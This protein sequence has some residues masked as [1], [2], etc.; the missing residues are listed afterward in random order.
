MSKPCNCKCG[1][2]GFREHG[3][4][5]VVLIRRDPPKTCQFKCLECGWKWWACRRYS[6]K[7]PDH[8][9]HSR[10]GMTD[11]D[12][13]DRLNDESLVVSANAAVFSMTQRGEKQL[14]TT[15]HSSNGSTYRFVEICSKG[16]KKKIALHRLVWMS[17]KRE[18]IPDG[19]DIDHINGKSVNNP[20]GI[21]NLRMI[22]SSANRSRGYVSPTPELPFVEDEVPF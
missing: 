5:W 6:A 20:D 15:E 13:L 17:H 1:P 9:E 14:A 22:E 4:R 19:F 18:L 8:T 7:C 3:S 11:Q 16:K 2:G 12:I 21:W 10:S